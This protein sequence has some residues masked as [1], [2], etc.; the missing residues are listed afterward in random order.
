MHT[1][2]LEWLNIGTV[3]QDMA[4]SI[5]LMQCELN[6]HRLAQAVNSVL[7]QQNLGS[8]PPRYPSRLPD[9]RIGT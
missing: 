2:A 5:L 9:Y 8:K 4:I 6:H 1:L 7:K 3:A